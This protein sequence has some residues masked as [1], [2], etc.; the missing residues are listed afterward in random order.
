M[1]DGTNNAFVSST[2]CSFATL[3]AQPVAPTFANCPGAA[4]QTDQAGVAI[5]PL[6]LGGSD[7]TLP[8]AY[9]ATGLPAGLTINAATGE[10]TGTPTTQQAAT[11]VTV[12]ITDADNRTVD[13]TFDWTIT[14]A[15]VD[16]TLTCPPAQS[17]TCLLY[18]SRCV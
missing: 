12:T 13:C 6:N 4:G 3:A 14:A 18:T 11:A 16:L 7:G 5:A 15:A 9:S 1:D 8:L 17:S 10:I 2:E